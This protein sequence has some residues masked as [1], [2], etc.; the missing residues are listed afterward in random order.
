MLDVDV[1]R[2]NIAHM[3]ECMA[4]VPAKL[5]PHVK[6]HKSPQIA[7]M[8]IQAGAI[9]VSTATVWEALAMAHAGIE[10]ILIA[11]QVVG[12]EKIAAVAEAA[13]LSAVTVAVD[14]PG[15]LEDLSAAA[16]AAGTEIGVLIEID[17]GMGRSGTR[18]AEEACRLA[19]HASGP[20]GLRFL[21]V[22]GYEGHCMLEPDRALRV[23]KA[24]AAMELLLRVVDV[25]A[26]AGYA[27][28]V[29]S[30]GGTGTYDITGRNPRV[31]ELQAGSYVFM[32]AFH[33]DLVPGFG[34]AL[35]VAATVISRHGNAIVLDV[36][37]KAIGSDLTMPRPAGFSGELVYLNEEHAGF[38][39][40]ATSPL[41]VG[42][43][44]ALVTG[45]GP[46]TVNLY[47]VYHV[48][49]GGV[50]VDIWPVA[51][52]GYGALSVAT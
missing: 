12:A 32:D 22:M 29:V 6:L 10:N 44:V 46:T 14:D 33:G 17:V 27:C 11:N 28:P 52:R 1:A 16:C 43:R 7:R 19:A 48:V 8:Q 5:R 49:S 25:L 23:T 47:E 36:G 42:D 40:E 31:T 3:A 45:Y 41:G 35:T 24:R 50:V 26:A 15:N 34:V 21:G 37:R 38:S 9:G 39:V 13:H 4:A 51:A 30:A 20:A 2:R 18:S